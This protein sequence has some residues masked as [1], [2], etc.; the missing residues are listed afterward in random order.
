MEEKGFIA[1]GEKLWVILQCKESLFYA[2]KGEKK[3]LFRVRKSKFT[4]S[5]HESIV[6]C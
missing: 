3:S 4:F 2:E 1:K 5:F 6:R